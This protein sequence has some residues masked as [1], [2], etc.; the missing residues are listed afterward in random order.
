MPP[1]A[2][3]TRIRE[4]VATVQMMDAPRFRLRQIVGWRF[5]E[6]PN[7]FCCLRNTV[8]PRAPTA[9]DSRAGSKSAVPARAS[10]VA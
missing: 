5:K 4:L 10:S 8:M 1:E 2:V 6:G 7:D 9:R 3:R